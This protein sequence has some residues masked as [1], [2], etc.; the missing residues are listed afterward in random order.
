MALNAKVK[1][2]HLQMRMNE[3]EVLYF[4]ANLWD[5]ARK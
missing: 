1:S 2:H 5:A 4:H 3:A